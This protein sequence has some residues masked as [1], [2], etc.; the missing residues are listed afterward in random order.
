MIRFSSS[1]PQYLSPD[2]CLLMLSA[3][4]RAAIETVRETTARNSSN[5]QQIRQSLPIEIVRETTATN[6][7][8][9][10]Q[11]RQSLHIETVRETT[12]TNSR[13][14][15]SCRLSYSFNMQTLS[16]LL[17]ITAVCSCCL[18]YRISHKY[19]IDVSHDMSGV[20]DTH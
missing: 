7:S 11:I 16:Y 2:S 18:S 6:S 13:N 4:L 5:R 17:S 19:S 20:H 14:R 12:A 9:R 10:Q 3:S 8:N 1:V 15:H